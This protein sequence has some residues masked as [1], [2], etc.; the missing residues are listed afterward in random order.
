M[1]TPDVRCMGTLKMVAGKTPRMLPR[2]LM[3]GNQASM[4][5]Q[6]FL[7][8][9]VVCLLKNAEAK[10]P[11]KWYSLLAEKMLRQI[12]WLKNAEAKQFLK[13]GV[14]CWLKNAEAWLKKA[15]KRAS[16]SWSRGSVRTLLIFEY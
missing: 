6:K 4:L 16:R 7:R 11:E 2:G 1:T 5:R 9:G 13:N 10:I 8:N 15:K 14:T 12:F 3:I